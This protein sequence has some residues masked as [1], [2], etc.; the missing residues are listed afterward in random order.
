MI[1]FHFVEVSGWTRN[2]E[3]FRGFLP[4]S[5]NRFTHKHVEETKENTMYWFTDRTPF[6]WIPL[7]HRTYQQ[8]IQFILTDVS[9]WFEEFSTPNPLGVSPDPKKTKIV[10]SNY[11]TEI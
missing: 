3:H 2:V 9:V 10:K 5:C 7:Q 8:V 1:I 11:E 6:E 4:R